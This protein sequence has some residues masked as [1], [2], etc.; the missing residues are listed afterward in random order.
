M[1]EI[2]NIIPN[3]VRSN[4]VS[5]LQFEVEK[6]DYSKLKASEDNQSAQSGETMSKDIHRM[7]FVIN[8]KEID[9]D[10]TNVLRY[11][12]TGDSG[13]RD[14]KIEEFSSDQRSFYNVGLNNKHLLPKS[15]DENANY[16]PFLIE[17]FKKLFTHAQ[18][19]VP[20][21]SI[22]QEL[23]T[24]CNQA[25]YFAYLAEGNPYDYKAEYSLITFNP[26]KVISIN[27]DSP[28]CAEI[29]INAETPVGCAEYGNVQLDENEE[30]YI[31]GHLSSSLEFKLESQVDEVKCTDGKLSF[32]FPQELMQDKNLLAKII[33]WFKELFGLEIK[34]SVIEH[35][36]DKAEI[37]KPQTKM[38]EGKV[39]VYQ[40]HQVG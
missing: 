30:K 6:L 26:S 5:T 18:A 12:G 9:Q 25:G 11:G 4:L 14:Y 2:I 13:G 40:T 33:E 7:V 37:D 22:I 38:E 21:D 15:T 23:I 1:A 19:E 31:I 8:G 39:E 32:T 17:A 36:F 24:N 34:G 27:C 16:R 28:N 35:S 29:K 10:L 3:N 20:D